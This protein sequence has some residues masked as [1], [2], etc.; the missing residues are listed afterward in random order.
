MRHFWL[1]TLLLT[2][3]LG[4]S[5][6]VTGT[7]DAVHAPIVRDLEAAGEAA[8]AGDWDA[9]G[10]L[11]ERAETRWT[12]KRN[13]VAALSSHSSIEE[14]ESLFRQ[15]QVYLR[16]G[17]PVVYAATCRE[18]A[19]LAQATSEAHQFTWWNLL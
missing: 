16:S 4:L 13:M 2:A 19:C 11:A 8:L 18:L 15:L 6:W 17:D 7:L 9:A 12:Q 10:T 14:I 1:G 5:L 3:L